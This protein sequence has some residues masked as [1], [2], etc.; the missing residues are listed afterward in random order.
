MTKQ[1]E[2]AFNNL[3][4]EAESIAKDFADHG[5]RAMAELDDACRRVREA[6]ADETTAAGVQ[7]QRK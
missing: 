3:L 5:S 2:E 4:L 6:Q 7:P 1:T